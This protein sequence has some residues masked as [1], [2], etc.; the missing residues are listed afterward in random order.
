MPAKVMEFLYITQQYGSLYLGHHV[1][2]RTMAKSELTTLVPVPE[3]DIVFACKIYYWNRAL[4][5]FAIEDL[6]LEVAPVF[7]TSG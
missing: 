7:T 2:R 6:L 4:V 5:P 3:N 1:V